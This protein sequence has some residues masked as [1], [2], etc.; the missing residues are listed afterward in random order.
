MKFLKIIWKKIDWK[1]KKITKLLNSPNWKKIEDTVFYCKF[2]TDWQKFGKFH[3]SLETTENSK[4]LE[5]VGAWI[6]FFGVES[7][8]M[9]TKKMAIPILQSIFLEKILQSCKKF[10]GKKH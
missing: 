3:Q 2:K 7:F 6:Y 4:N 1:L 8:H 9:A 10:G 5:N